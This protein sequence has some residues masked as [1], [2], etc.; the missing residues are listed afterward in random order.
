MTMQ[1]QLVI[2]AERGIQY[3]R[4]FSIESGSRGVLD[5]PVKP[6]DDSGV[7]GEHAMSVIL[8]AAA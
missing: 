6:G 7:V 2:P 3:S 8:L 1:K 4:G 5:R